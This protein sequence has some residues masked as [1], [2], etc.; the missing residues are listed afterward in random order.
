[1]SKNTNTGTDTTTPGSSND[2]LH[3]MNLGLKRAEEVGLDPDE[4]D[5]LTS[6][7]SECASCRAEHTPRPWSSVLDVGGSRHWRPASRWR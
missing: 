7:L 6:H 4:A 1:M 5:W 3:A 2:C